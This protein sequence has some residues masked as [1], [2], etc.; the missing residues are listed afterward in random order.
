VT[1]LGWVGGGTTLEKCNHSVID[2]HGGQAC[3]QAGCTNDPMIFDKGDGST[4]D[5]D[6]GAPFYLK[7]GGDAYIRGMVIGGE[8]FCD[9]NSTAHRWSTVATQLG[10]TIAT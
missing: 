10:V 5:G 8:F 6:S 3:D 4:C 1:R 9:G 7:S 2:L